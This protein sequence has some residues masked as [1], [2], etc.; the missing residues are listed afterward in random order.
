MT[1]IFAI[2]TPIFIAHFA[3]ADFKRAKNLLS[4]FGV[5]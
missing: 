5:S 1:A 4:F 2:C 3:Y